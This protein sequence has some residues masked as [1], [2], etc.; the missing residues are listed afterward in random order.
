MFASATLPVPV[1]VPPIEWATGSRTLTPVT[2]AETRITVA[3]GASD[4]NP[5]V[6]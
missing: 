3:L 1:T 5:A 2:A 4:T 6:L